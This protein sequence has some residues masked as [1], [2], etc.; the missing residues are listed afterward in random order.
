MDH[1]LLPFSFAGSGNLVLRPHVVRQNIMS[2][3]DQSTL[4]PETW[5]VKDLHMA[6]AWR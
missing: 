6:E 1:V 2:T 3:S 5:D 4:V